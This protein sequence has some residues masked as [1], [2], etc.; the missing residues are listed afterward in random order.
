MAKIKLAEGGFTVVPEGKHIF[1]ITKSTY[2]SDFGKLEV[3]MVTAQGVKHHER[4]N[5]I[6]E[7]GELNEGA[8]KAFSYFA[9]T[10]LNNFNL[11]EVDSDDI[12]GC[13]IE[14][15]V[16][17]EKLPNRKDPA[18]TVVFARLGDKTPASGFNEVSKNTAPA[19]G[20][21]AKG[22]VDLDALLG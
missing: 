3:E 12:V 7:D 20:S 13:Y 4:Y 16:E 19:S 14:A 2:D 9:K 6:N 18:K 10:A 22:V 15:T 1:K 5:F 8:Q 11:E 21:T 17:H